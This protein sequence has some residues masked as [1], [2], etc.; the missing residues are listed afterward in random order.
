MNFTFCTGSNRRLLSASV[1]VYLKSLFAHRILYVFEGLVVIEE[2]LST[3]HVHLEDKTERDWWR[4]SGAQAT[5]SA[6]L[7]LNRNIS[8][9]VYLYSDWYW[10]SKKCFSVFVKEKSQKMSLASL[11]KL[12]QGSLS[13]YSYRMWVVLHFPSFLSGIPSVV[14]QQ[15]YL[16]NEVVLMYYFILV[17][18]FQ[19]L[20]NVWCR[21][22]LFHTTWLHWTFPGASR[23]S[24]RCKCRCKS[25]LKWDVSRKCWSDFTIK[26]YKELGWGPPLQHKVSAVFGLCRLQVYPDRPA[27]TRPGNQRNLLILM[28]MLLNTMDTETWAFCQSE[29]RLCS[30][31]ARGQQW[32][33]SDP[34]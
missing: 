34:S 32:H 25:L 29:K 31:E 27:E 21:H 9:R 12:V 2:V 23:F 18:Y 17:Y 28:H 13:V 6:L 19:D 20:Q 26:K 16:R 8:F 22:S 10:N 33:F 24:S 30:Y 3:N 4:L 1:A 7:W 14:L 15:S 5:K 11:H